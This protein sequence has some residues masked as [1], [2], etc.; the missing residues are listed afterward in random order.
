M[1]LSL[2]YFWRAGEIDI[3]SAT[4]VIFV[5]IEEDVMRKMI[6]FKNINLNFHNSENKSLDLT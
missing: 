5:E 3:S 4:V 1:G 6:Y 2:I